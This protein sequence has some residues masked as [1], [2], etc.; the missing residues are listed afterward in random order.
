[1]VSKQQAV[2]RRQE[3]TLRE[4]GREGLHVLVVEDDAA[5]AHLILRALSEQG[6]KVAHIELASDGVEALE[7]L[8]ESLMSPDMAIIDLKMPRMDG[9][10]LLIEMACRGHGHVPVV[11]LTSSTAKADA[12]RSRFRGAKQVISKPNNL[13]ELKRALATSLAEV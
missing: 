3:E 9:F 10:K 12:V 5:D 11:V 7:R 13:T 8:E 2:M 4:V 6:A 1:M